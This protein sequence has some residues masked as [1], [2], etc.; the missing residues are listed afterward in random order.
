MGGGL[1]VNRAYWQPDEAIRSYLEGRARRPYTPIYP[2]P[3]AIYAAEHHYDVS[4]L[5]PMVACPDS[6]D[7]VKPVSE[8]AGTP[9]QQ[10]FIDTCTN[11]RLEDIAA[12]AQ[13]VKG[14][15]V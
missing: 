10:A 14:H 7:N 5:E 15:Q 2:D 11:D 13:M 1:G 9:V 8:I 3:A 6:P 4:Q 12:A